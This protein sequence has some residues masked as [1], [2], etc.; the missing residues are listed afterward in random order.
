MFRFAQHDKLKDCPMADYNGFIEENQ[1]E[2]LFFE[3][4]RANRTNFAKASLAKEVF[5]FKL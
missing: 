3:R 5:N 1:F 4:N 2:K